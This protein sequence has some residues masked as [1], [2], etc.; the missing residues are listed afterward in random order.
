ME[1][2][3]FLKGVQ[4]FQC[5]GDEECKI[6]ADSLNRREIRRGEYLFRKGDE[7]STLYIVQSGKIK[8]TIPSER[9]EE[10]IPAI[11]SRGECFGE[12][13]LLDGMPRSADAVALENSE[14]FA[15]NRGDFIS[16]LHQHK[17][18]IAAVMTFL[19]M[20][21]RKT[22]GLLADICFLSVPER[23]AKRLAVLA[24]EQGTP[25][26]ESGAVQISISMTQTDLA[27]LVGTSRETVN[28]ELRILRDAGLID[29]DR[30]NI[31]IHNI[32]ELKRRFSVL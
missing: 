19:S 24:E 13:A 23:L 7:G 28:R 30:N 1:A 10:V 2:G 14:L 3:E 5:L 31:T 17:E 21:L 6:L 32:K 25:R 8:I 11:L 12:M 4:L 18:A 22:D 26:E 15:L 16:F 20:R 27:N 9:G 29:I